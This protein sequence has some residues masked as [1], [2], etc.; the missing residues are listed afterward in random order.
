MLVVLVTGLMGSGKSEVLSLLE[1][2]GYA[3]F[4]ADKSAKDFL[5]PKSPCFSQIERI[6]GSHL[7]KPDGS[8][9]RAKVAQAIFSNPSQLKQ[10]EDIL[11]PLVQKEFKDFVK[12]HKDKG[13]S[14]IFYEMPPIPKSINKQRFPV[15]ICVQADKDIA[16]KRLKKRGFTEKDIYFR[17]KAQMKEQEILKVSNFKINN[18]GDLKHLS[19]Q[20]DIIIKEIDKKG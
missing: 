4:Q 2:K 1:L 5:S 3:G 9:D 7:L 20:L 8:F 11:H 6:L 18:N 13:Q 12:S 15:V 17:W 14:V 19:Q 10:I 16:L